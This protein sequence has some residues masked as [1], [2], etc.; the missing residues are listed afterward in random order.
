MGAFPD[1][2]DVHSAYGAASMDRWLDFD[3]VHDALPGG[4]LDSAARRELEVLALMAEPRRPAT[5]S[6]VG[7][8]RPRLVV[9]RG[10]SG[11]P[12]GEP[13]GWSREGGPPAALS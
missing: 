3:L 11:T 7:R 6:M 1:A 2:H 13:S 8:R 10:G 12:D 9:L 5:D 4:A